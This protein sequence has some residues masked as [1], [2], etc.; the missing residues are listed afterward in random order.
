VISLASRFVVDIAEV[1]C[2]DK[3]VEKIRD[4]HPPL[5]F[6]DVR[7]ALI[8]ARDVRV[9]WVED[10][11]HGRRLA[12][13]GRT[14]KGTQFIAYLSPVSENDPEEGTYKLRTAIPRPDVAGND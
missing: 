10:D 8:Y 3:I 1:L 11:E 14:L 9:S 6:A 4:K 5:T 7:Q 13:R 2:E 12:A